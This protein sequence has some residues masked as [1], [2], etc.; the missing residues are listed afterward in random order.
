MKKFSS[1]ISLVG[2]L[3]AALLL[4][5][6]AGTP[7]TTGPVPE[8]HYRVQPGDNLYR[9]GLRFNQNAAT[10]ARWNNLQD[11]T[12]IEVGQVLR[13]RANA[14]E[15]A[16]ATPRSST[17]GEVKPV[18]RMALQWPL[19]N[20]SVSKPYDGVSNKGIDM[21]GAPGTPIKAAAD[22]KVLYAGN[23]VRGYGNLILVSHSGGMLTAYA[24]NDKL[25]VSKDQTVRA[26]Q[27][28]ATMGSSDTDNTKLHFEVRVNGKAVNPMLYLN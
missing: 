12:Q 7:N 3:A 9:I 1:R 18:N 20:H 19:D 2:A 27:Q 28:I 8:G 21:A 5:A 13:V 17:T 23:G 15:R 16:V 26:G 25:L 22:G 24:H 6:C 11:P 10:L 14:G 4:A